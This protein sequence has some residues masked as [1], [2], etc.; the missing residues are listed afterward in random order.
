[1]GQ[2]SVDLESL[3]TLVPVFRKLVEGGASCSLK[4]ISQN[5]K[6]KLLLIAETAVP[7]LQGKRRRRRKRR[8]RDQERMRRF[9]AKKKEDLENQTLLNVEQSLLVELPTV[10]QGGM[11]NPQPSALQRGDEFE[12]GESPILLDPSPEQ[13]LLDELPITQPGG[14]ERP[15][16]SILQQ[17]DVDGDSPI[18]LNP[19]PRHRRRRLEL[20]PICQLDGDDSQPGPLSMEKV[21][22]EISI[23]E[24]IQKM[25]AKNREAISQN[26]RL[27]FKKK[28][29]NKKKI[30]F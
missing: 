4:Y 6:S 29:K 26:P 14:R 5:G 9:N 20:S 27:P 16:P 10:Q 11:D 3:N 24:S 21:I 17:G 7:T 8:G 28:I 19:S 23:D 13:P 18:L 15:L 22:N 1:M 2:P 30:W 12:T 25:L